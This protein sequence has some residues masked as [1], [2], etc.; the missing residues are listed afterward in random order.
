MTILKAVVFAV[1][2]WSL[3]FSFILFFFGTYKGH[4]A[5]SYYL[6]YLSIALG[7]LNLNIKIKT[8]GEM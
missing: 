2:V 7:V 3:M 1:S 5:A 4:E 8:G 6:L